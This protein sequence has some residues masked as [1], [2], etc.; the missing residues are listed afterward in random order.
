MYPN[1]RYSKSFL[2]HNLSVYL[3]HYLPAF[4]IDAIN[5]ISKRNRKLMLPIAKKFKHACLAG[6]LCHQK[7]LKMDFSFFQYVLT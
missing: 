4:L 3:L 5:L 6:I 1:F 2:F 7:Y